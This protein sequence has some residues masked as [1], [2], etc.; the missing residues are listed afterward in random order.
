V[1]AAE[2]D[3][4]ETGNGQRNSDY[5]A[6]TRALAERDDCQRDREYRLEGRDHRREPGRQPSVHRHEENAELPDPDEQTD[7]DDHAPPHV[8]SWQ[9]EDRW[10]S[11]QS[12][13]QGGKEKRRE[14]LETDVDD[15]EVHGPADGHDES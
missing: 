10:E 8:W 2:G 4:A 3:R 12:E 7:G 6:Q 15:D 13:A 1:G 14:R 11:G 9:E 5:L